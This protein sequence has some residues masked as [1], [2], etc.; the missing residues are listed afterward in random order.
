MNLIG[1]IAEQP[2]AREPA[3]RPVLK[4]SVSRRPA[5]ACIIRTWLTETRTQHVPVAVLT[6]IRNGR[7]AMS[8]LDSPTHEQGIA[9]S[10]N[11]AKQ[12]LCNSAAMLMSAI[13]AYLL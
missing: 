7:S 8:H 2:H 4:S 9:I 12:Q 10:R 1:A 6:T 13:L 3:V 5:D 11:F